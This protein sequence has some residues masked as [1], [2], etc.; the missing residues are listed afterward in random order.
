MVAACR[1]KPM[2]AA[3]SAP[4]IVAPGV[5]LKRSGSRFRNS[6]PAGGSPEAAAPVS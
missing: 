2:S 3:H 1:V 5:R 6:G 4:E